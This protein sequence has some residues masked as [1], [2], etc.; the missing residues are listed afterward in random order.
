MTNIHFASATPHAQCNLV[1]AVAQEGE[2]NI[3]YYVGKAMTY[4]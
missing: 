1:H 2:G 3:M 4:S